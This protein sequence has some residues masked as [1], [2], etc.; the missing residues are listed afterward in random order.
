[1][2][3]CEIEIYVGYDTGVWTTYTIELIDEGIFPLEDLLYH[4]MEEHKK[5]YPNM[6]FYGIYKI[7]NHPDYILK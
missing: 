1:M 4:Y 6:E 2:I 5:D 3:K 7:K